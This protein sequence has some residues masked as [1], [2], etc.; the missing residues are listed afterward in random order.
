MKK[1]FWVLIAAM[2][3]VVVC[4]FAACNDGS[5]PQNP[6]EEQPKLSFAES[7]VT[8]ERYKTLTL[9]PE[10]SETGVIRWASSNESRA[11]VSQSGEVLAKAAGVVTITATLGEDSATCTV[12][13]IDSGY[14]PTVRVVLPEDGLVLAEGDEYTLAP[15][16]LYDGEAYTDGTFA[17]AAEGNVTVSENGVVTAGTAGSGRVKI[18][19][20]WRGAEEKTLTAYIDVTVLAI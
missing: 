1:R 2:L 10:T 7:V 16:V 11:T 20:S 18:V 3:S 17:Y 19:A 15:T 13:V 6:V 5:Q 14:I 4:C 12:R 8:L 9:S